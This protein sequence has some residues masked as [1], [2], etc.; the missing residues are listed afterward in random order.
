MVISKL[1]AEF[2]E[3]KYIK[4]IYSLRHPIT[5]EIFYVG[6]TGNLKN[7]LGNHI[8]SS[9]CALTN[10]LSSSKKEKIIAEITSHKMTP[11]M[12]IIEEIEIRTNINEMYAYAKESYWINFYRSIG[13][14]LSNTVVMRPYTVK[15]D[16]NKYI[17]GEGLAYSHYYMGINSD[18]EHIYDLTL[19]NKQG[20]APPQI[21]KE[22]KIRNTHYE[23]IYDDDNPDYIRSSQ[24]EI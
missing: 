17:T 18:G 19:L 10:P 20:F 23:Y 21:K 8:S 14:N 11:I 3:P 13:W 2:Y 5:Y 7:R 12:R 4:Y 6:L 1:S 22:P 16:L 9:H 24:E 15:R